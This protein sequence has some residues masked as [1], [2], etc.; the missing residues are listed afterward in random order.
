MSK[1]NTWYILA[2]KDNRMRYGYRMLLSS[3]ERHI[4]TDLIE[5]TFAK[6][7]LEEQKKKK[8]VILKRTCTPLEV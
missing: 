6:I 8:L 7:A 3:K 4:Y 1:T 2:R 5:A